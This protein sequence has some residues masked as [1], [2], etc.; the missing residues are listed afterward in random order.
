MSGDVVHLTCPEP[1]IAVV[2]LADRT[3]S[4]TFSPAMVDGLIRSFAAIAAAEDLRVVVVHGYGSIFCPGGTRDELLG[5][6]EGRIKFDDLPLYRLFLDCPV[7]VIAAMQGHALGGGLAMGLFADMV[8]LAEEALYGANFMKYGFT[9]GMGATLVIP[10]RF[11]G[12]LASEMMF[13][14]AS[15]HGGELA[16]RGIGCRVLRRAEVIPAAMRLAREVAD[17]PVVSV[18]LLKA[19]LAA[20]LRAALPATV[21]AELEMHKTTFVQP[22]VRQRIETLF[23][24]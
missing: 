9:P 6:F 14:A 24:S 1:G 21:A 18:R 22:V 3:H 2:E 17:K 23:G 16:R 13:S 15:Y 20:P 7:P 8:I 19:H 5:I 4:N 11:G 10:A 12:L